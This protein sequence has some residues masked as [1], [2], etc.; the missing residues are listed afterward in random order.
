MPFSPESIAARNARRAKGP[1]ADG[2]P[3]ELVPITTRTRRPGPAP[4][5]AREDDQAA[6]RDLVFTA[7]ATAFAR[8]GFDGVGVD[9]IAR[10]A[11]V[12]KAMLYYHF[13]SKLELYRSIVRDMLQAVRTAVTA[14]AE[15]DVVPPVKIERFIET[16][17]TMRHARPWF[18]PLMM[19]ELSAGAP[20]LDPDT[21]LLMRGVFTAFGRI[22]EQGVQSGHFRPVHPV[23]A[24]V[25]ILGPMMMNAVRERAAAEPGR[26]HLPMFVAIP[27]QDLIAHMQ[28]TALSMLAK[29]TTR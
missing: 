5:T 18:P 19:R 11:G 27:R 26:A 20:H 28:H 14:L 21:L 13:R 22:L 6:T 15:S 17:A 10:A 4:A 29:D 24:Y 3:A 25:T 7:A 16:L 12:N 9:A 8:D 2:S 23:L 1:N